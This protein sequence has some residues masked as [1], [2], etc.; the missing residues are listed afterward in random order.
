[1]KKLMVFLLLVVLLSAASFAGVREEIESQVKDINSTKLPWVAGV[2]QSF[3]DLEQMLW[4]NGMSVSY[5]DIVTKLNGYRDLLK[6]DKALKADTLTANDDVYE[7]SRFVYKSIGTP[8]HTSYIQIHTPVKNQLYHGT[9][10]AFSTTAAFESALLVQRDKLTGSSD[11]ASPLEL[12]NDTYDLSEQYTSYHN[13]DWDVYR[14]SIYAGYYT[15]N[16]TIQLQDCNLDAGGN[17][18]F[19]TFNLIRY[20]ITTEEKMPYQFDRNGWISWNAKDGWKEEIDNNYFFASK[21]TYI[22][23]ADYAKARGFDYE[24]YIKS[25]KELLVTNG[26][27]MVSYAVPVDFDVYLGGIYVPSAVFGSYVDAGLSPY[28]GG[29]AVSLVG[30]ADMAKIKT[31][32]PTMVDSDATYIEWTNYEH[33]VG[34][35]ASKNQAT[36]FW[37]I[38]NS[39]GNNWGWHGYYLVPMIT[40]AQYDAF[41]GNNAS[42]E[43]WM[44]ESR[45]IFS[46]ILGEK[47]FYDINDNLK[48]ID[49]TDDHSV[50]DA[51]YALI[52]GKVT[53]SPKVYEEKYDISAVK[54]GVID[55]DDLEMFFIISAIKSSFK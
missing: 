24:T 8:V 47:A 22:P 15:G 27:L 29:H 52:L 10:W 9:C 2:N 33:K 55:Y 23:S 13:I 54:D 7:A 51:D 19:S 17:A 53:E 35:V 21:T 18:Y 42:I 14:D 25:I 1:M 6:E 5:K 44:I 39:W 38:K 48:V 32:F 28:D 40:Q 43:D 26:A 45:D 49:F 12:E 16:G 11:S 46:T 31:M 34:G 50:N 20:G 36:E 30:W 4:N 41:D 37:I 3:L